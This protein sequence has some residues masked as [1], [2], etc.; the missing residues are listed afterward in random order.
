MPA[1]TNNY[2]KNN[3]PKNK[4]NNNKTEKQKKPYNPRRTIQTDSKYTCEYKMSS[5]MAYE[6]LKDHKDGDVQKILCDWVNQNCGLL[7]ECVKVVTD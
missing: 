7:W 4:N 5:V 2:K 1:Q 6:I 3:N